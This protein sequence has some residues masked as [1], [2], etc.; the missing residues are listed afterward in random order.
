MIEGTSFKRV[1]PEL[2]PASQNPE[3]CRRVIFCSGKVYYELVKE[4]ASRGLVNDIA[5]TRV[6]QICPF[7]W[8]LL[9][10]EIKKYPN[11]E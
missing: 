6:E 4:R 9:T 8:D 2:G 3:N 10:E 5:I 11:A 7:P 1:I